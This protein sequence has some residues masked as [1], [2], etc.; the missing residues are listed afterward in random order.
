[1]HFTNKRVITLILLSILLINAGLLF[2]YVFYG[3]QELFHSD[4]AVKVLLAKEIFETGNYFP[5]DWNYV[6]EDLMMFFGQ[7]F[8][9]PLLHFLP[10]GYTVHAISGSIVA[11]LILLGVWLLSGITNASIHKRI[12]I[13]AIIAGGISGI[14][15]ENFYGQVSYGFTF[16]KLCFLIFFSWKYLTIEKKYKPYYAIGISIIVLVSFWG[17]PQRAFI[18]YQFPL[19]FSLLYY[20]YAYKLTKQKYDFNVL[21]LFFF[22]II[23]S[24]LGFLFHHI[25][26]ENTNNIVG[27]A[28]VRWASYDDMLLNISLFLKQFF[29]IMNGLPLEKSTIISISSVESALRLV[30]SIMLIILIVHLFINLNLKKLNGITFISIFA[31]VSFFVVTFLQITTTL[32]IAEQS[33]RYIV[34]STILLV[35]LVLAKNYNYDKNIFLFL[36][37]I[38][39][40]LLLLIQGYTVYFKTDEN[41]LFNK[42]VHMLKNPK[43]LVNF[44]IKNNLKHGYATYW[45]AGRVSVLS[46]E[47]VLIRQIQLHTGLPIPKRW[48]SSDSWYTSKNLNLKTFLL[49]SK[50]ESEK[51]DL[52]TLEVHS[53]QVQDILKY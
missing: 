37:S 28:N 35:I 11:L 23:S 27:V 50:E 29:Q 47:K 12:I 48:L 42:N 46:N 49:L 7:T 14:V 53:I 10:A 5:E 36:S 3:Y 40:S 52:K 6:N 33:S 1:M 8:I 19:L 18:T 24:I 44:L 17:N 31:V 4:S 34:P 9:I 20:L 38:V 16:F 45:N 51:F 21:K 39:I 26:L 25:T 2:W 32:P 15:A 30:S 22:I 41:L 13:V 43:K